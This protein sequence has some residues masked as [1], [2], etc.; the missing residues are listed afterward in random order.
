V[1]KRQ[2]ANMVSFLIMELERKGFPNA[3]NF[4]D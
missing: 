2:T 3:R 4:K 1:M